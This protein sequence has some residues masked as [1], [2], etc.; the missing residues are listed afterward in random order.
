MHEYNYT[1]NINMYFYNLL[2]HK[3]Y[4]K[5]PHSSYTFSLAMTASWS[6]STTLRTAAINI[7][8]R[9]P[10]SRPSSW[11]RTWPLS[12]RWIID[13]L[14]LCRGRT[15]NAKRRSLTSAMTLR[16]VIGLAIRS[17]LLGFRWAR[18]TVSLWFECSKRTQPPSR[19][20]ILT[21]DSCRTTL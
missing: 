12:A 6:L 13:R 5:V 3:N 11:T 8:Y 18:L 2:Q 17:P 16:D 19:P 4:Q 10:R 15:S 14:S 1:A 20:Y 7:V 21:L 9:Y